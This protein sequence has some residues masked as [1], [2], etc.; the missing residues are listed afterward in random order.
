MKTIQKGEI[1]QR[2]YYLDVFLG[3]EE[4][5]PVSIERFSAIR[6]NA[7]DISLVEIEREV[8]RVH[9]DNPFWLGNFKGL[10]CKKISLDPSLLC[11]DKYHRKLDAILFPEGK[12]HYL[13]WDEN[14]THPEVKKRVEFV[15]NNPWLLTYLPPVVKEENG[16]YHVL[17]GNHRVMAA[18]SKGEKSIPVLLICDSNDS[19]CLETLNFC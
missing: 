7:E 16:L 9:K 13:F 15:I 18:I 6:S 14:K 10:C 12:L 19:D 5:K 8:E 2:Y 11:A 1:L 4:Q 17:S 3:V